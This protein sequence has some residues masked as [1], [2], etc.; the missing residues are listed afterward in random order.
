VKYQINAFSII[1]V[2]KE[3]AKDRAKEEYTS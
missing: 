2:P 3:L 1:S